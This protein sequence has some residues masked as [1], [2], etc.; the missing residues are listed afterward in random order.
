MAQHI[1]DM[2]EV[3]LSNRR[4][5]TATQGEISSFLY[6]YTEFRYILSIII[7]VRCRESLV[8]VDGESSR[9]FSYLPPGR[10]SIT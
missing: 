10:Q 3:R 8:N 4:K 2:I 7:I 1:S 5:A 6:A 9:R